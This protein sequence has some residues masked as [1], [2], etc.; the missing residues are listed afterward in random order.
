MEKNNTIVFGENKLT[1]KYETETLI[2]EKQKNPSY[3]K[4]T[5]YID[6]E[7]DRYFLTK[8]KS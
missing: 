5:E 6:F 1:L 8:K 7:R 3:V 4:G 2:F